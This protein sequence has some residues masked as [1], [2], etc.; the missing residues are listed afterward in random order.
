MVIVDAPV[1]VS[2]RSRPIPERSSAIG[3]TPGCRANF[4]LRIEASHRSAAAKCHARSPDSKFLVRR[5]S[6]T[7]EITIS[8]AYG[9][10]NEMPSSNGGFG[11]KN[12]T[13]YAVIPSET[14][15][16]THGALITR[17]IKRAPRAFERSLTPFGMTR[18]FILFKLE[19]YSV[20]LIF[21]PTPSPFTFRS[22]IDSANTGGTTNSPR[23]DD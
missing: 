21:P 17:R 23:L 13:T 4:C 9:C 5:E 15:D 16:L 14:R 11:N 8:I 20:T 12:Q 19:T 7:K 3:F 22:Y 1:R 6:E 2:P 18:V 10:E